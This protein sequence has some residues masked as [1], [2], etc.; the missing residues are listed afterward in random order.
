MSEIKF[1]DFDAIFIVGLGCKIERL[2]DTFKTHKTYDSPNRQD[3]SYQTISSAC[4][5][6]ACMDQLKVAAIFQIISLI[7]SASKIPVFLSPCPLP[8]KACAEISPFLRANA[9]KTVQ[10]C[11][12]QGL[13]NLCKQFSATLLTQPEHT[14]TDYVFTKSMFSKGAVR[15]NLKSL[16]GVTDY[17]HMNRE[18][19][20]EVLTHH[21]PVICGW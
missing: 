8:S 19:G 13:S 1:A 9:T 6:Q 18:Y 5:T 7:R 15:L 17:A 4:L 11:F 20:K 2:F 12:Y 14:V 3:A 21:L 10:Q 16:C